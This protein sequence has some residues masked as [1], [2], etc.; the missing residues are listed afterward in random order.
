[1]L[2]C[3]AIVLAFLGSILAGLFGGGAGLIVT[4]SIYM[5]LNYSNAQATGLMQTS[6]TTMIGSLMLAGA[7]GIYKHATYDHIEW[8]VVKKSAP[9]VMVGAALGCLAMS[10]ISNRAMVLIFA[11]ATL[12]LAIRSTLQL[13]GKNSSPNV[14][15]SHSSYSPGL[16]YGGGLLLGIVSTLSGAASF[17]V[18]YYEYL[19]LT[20]KKAIG[21]TTVIVWLYSIV[22]LIFMVS[23]GW[24]V[25]HLPAHNMG[26]LNYYYLILF[27]LPTIPGTLLGARWARVLPTYYLKLFFTLLLYV[28]GIS[29][30]V[31]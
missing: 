10:H 21:T 20:I 25:H 11:I 30:L 4:P 15:M 9:W 26:Y 17:A 31:F 2:I 23:S 8:S 5:L 29:M 6:I 16:M 1:M 27:L 24:H 3:A 14:G 19:G 13:L 28:I 7:I 18:P 12:V 22:V